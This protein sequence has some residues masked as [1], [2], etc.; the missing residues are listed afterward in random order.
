MSHVILVRPGC[1]E[2]DEQ[3]RIQGTL[4]LPL[5]AQGDEQVQR[6]ISEL[7]QVSLD[8]ICTSPCEPA[9]SCAE[10]IGAALAVP[11]KELDGL[12][13]LNQGLWQGLHID[14][15][16][17]KHPR[18][19]KQWQESP[20]TVCP[21]EGE[22]LWD[23]VCRV[24]KALEKP[25]RKNSH[26][27]IIVPEPLASVVRCVV[28]NCPVEAIALFNAPADGRTWEY[29]TLNGSTPADGRFACVAEHRTP[30]AA[31]A[32]SIAVPNGDVADEYRRK[33]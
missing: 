1:T 19:F 17:R 31:G 25:L 5:S 30:Q 26:V 2:F 14:D 15:I 20:E 23:V 13:N 3:Q 16:R 4:D 18:V 24:K 7:S 21:P 28:R 12:Q 29:L 11:V 6:T 27:A 10:R 22:M 33:N 9:R 32:V 8:L